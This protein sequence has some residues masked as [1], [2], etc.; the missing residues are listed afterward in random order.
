MTVTGEWPAKANRWCIGGLPKE[1]ATA[2]AEQPAQPEE[3]AE[4][5]YTLAEARMIVAREQCDQFGHAL[6]NGRVYGAGGQIEHVVTCVRCG[7]AFTE[8]GR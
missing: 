7:A 2:E 1:E 4:P 5:R 3:P 6:S 8:V